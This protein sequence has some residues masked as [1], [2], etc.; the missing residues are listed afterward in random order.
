MLGDCFKSRNSGGAALL[1][2]SDPADA[3]HFHLRRQRHV[4][5]MISWLQT[6][7]Q[8]NNKFLFSILLIVIIVAFVFTIGDFGGVGPGSRDDKLAAQKF[9]GYDLN[10]Q[11]TRTDLSRWSEISLQLNMQ[12]YPGDQQFTLLVLQRV[13]GLHL[14]EQLQI[15]TP[16]NNEFTRYIQQV[17]AFRDPQTGAFSPNRSQEVIDLF[18]SNPQMGEGLLTLVLVQD[19]RIDKALELVGGPGYVLPQLAEST[20]QGRKT[21]W[22]LEIA[23]LSRADF[24]PQID[25]SD[26]AVEQYYEANKERYKPENEVVAGYALLPV[27][28]FTASV[29]E[30]AQGELENFYQSNAA[31]WAKTDAGQPKPLAD[32]RAEVL[33]AWKQDKADEL[34]ETAANQLALAVYNGVSNG[35]VKADAQSVATFL[36]G[37]KLSLVTLP[38]FNSASLAQPGAEQVQ[39]KQRILGLRGQ[40]RFFSDAISLED[41]A[42][43][44][45]IFGEQEQPIPALADIRQRVQADLSAEQNL[46][47]F[48]EKTQS[49][50]TDL[51]KALAEG[52]SFEDAAKALDLSVQKPAPF[53]LE[54]L[55]QDINTYFL[56]AALELQKGELSQP[57]NDAEGSNVIYVAERKLP[58]QAL[59]AEEVNQAITWMEPMIQRATIS[60]VINDMLNTGALA[61]AEAAAY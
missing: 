5:N 16:G 13:I 14:A 34:A 44:A 6:V 21:Q 11:R 28:D 29:G 3:H 1:H 12:P 47:L 19:Y 17:P 10:N 8:R 38:A 51:E 57:L 31:R 54:T 46:R 24:K 33:A 56:F 26:A 41:G 61:E 23:T 52:K 50:R 40:E 20:V 53:T 43:V 42:A 59:S 45:F 36:E 15:P 22:A 60:S 2:L 25:L 37:R 27:A 32:I 49:I 30:P 39:L 35:S 18:N 9:Y 55:P 7:I 4:P 48:A 58:E